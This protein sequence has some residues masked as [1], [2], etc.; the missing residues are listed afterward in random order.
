MPLRS[1]IIFFLIVCNL[2]LSA[3]KE[4]QSKRIV[5]ILTFNIYHGATMK[6]DFNLDVLANL[7]KEANPDLVAMQEVDF[8]TNRAKG[9]D[10]PTELGWRTK[11][12]PLFGKA[13][14][15]SGGEYGE[16][17]LSRWSFISSQNIAL[18]YL[19][20]KEPRAALMITT[21]TD[22]GDTISFVATH[23]DHEGKES[24]ILQTNKINEELSKN[25][26]PTILAG[27][28]NDIPGSETINILEEHW[29]PTYNKENP[30]FTYP[31][32]SPDRKIDYIMYRPR[33]KWRVLET[34]VIQDSIASD[35]YAYLVTLE[36]LQ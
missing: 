18:P 22:F 29:T 17:V 28:L 8:K 3:Q 15:Y 34:K 6:G 32:T 9:Y 35:H 23:L 31:S 30:T 19:T 33:D 7:I 16:A 10:L 27:D 13:M 4:I 14:P 20:G 36:L 26:Y 25:R 1:L 21:V 5:R 24:R 11:L 2:S 12:A